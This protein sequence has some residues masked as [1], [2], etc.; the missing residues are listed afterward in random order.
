LQEVEAAHLVTVCAKSGHFPRHQAICNTGIIPAAG[1]NYRKMRLTGQ[2]RFEWPVLRQKELYDLARRP[3]FRVPLQENSTGNDGYNQNGGNSYETKEPVRKCTRPSRQA[4]VRLMPLLV[5]DLN[6][7][8]FLGAHLFP[9]DVHEE[10]QPHA[11]L[12]A[13]N[14]MKLAGSFNRGIEAAFEVFA[15]GLFGQA[16]AMIPTVHGFALLLEEDVICSRQHA[17][18]LMETWTFLSVWSLFLR[19]V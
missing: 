11:A 14:Q 5:H 18:I 13:S 7:T 19:L 16:L 1:L 3:R 10:T 9:E 4:V 15:Q 8:R 12:I 2:A 6:L 17:K